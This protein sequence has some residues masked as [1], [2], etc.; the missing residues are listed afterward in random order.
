MNRVEGRNDS[1]NGG[2]RFGFPGGEGKI[3]QYSEA[4]TGSRRGLYPFQWCSATTRLTRD[5]ERFYH[6]CAQKACPG[7]SS[8]KLVFLTTI[9]KGRTR[10][11]AFM[12]PAYLPTVLRKTGVGELYTYLKASAYMVRSSK[13]EEL[14]PLKL[15]RGLKKEVSVGCSVQKMTCS[16]CGADLKHGRCPA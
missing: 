1:E 9:P 10:R 14:I 7:C 3:N 8:A 4:G 5:G 11:R 2:N 16:I 6:Q 15:T 13:T 12:T